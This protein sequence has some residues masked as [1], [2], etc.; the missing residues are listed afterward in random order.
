VDNSLYKGK[1]KGV[2]RESWA[3]QAKT[4]ISNP[5]AQFFERKNAKITN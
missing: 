4:A 1:K 5:D 3:K 2:I